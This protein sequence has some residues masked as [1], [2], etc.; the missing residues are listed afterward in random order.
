MPKRLPPRIA[1]RRKRLL[2]GAFFI[3]AAGGAGWFV[4]LTPFFLIKNIGVIVEGQ[5]SIPSTHIQEALTALESETPNILFF[6]PEK[7]EHR[8]MARFSELASA[9]VNRRLVRFPPFKKA[10]W[11]I[12]EVE[13]NISER[14][15]LGVT[16]GSTTLTTGRGRCYFFDRDGMLFRDFGGSTGFTTGG[17]PA[18]PFIADKRNVAY[19]LRYQVFSP[20]TAERLADLLKRSPAA[21][22]GIE[23]LE[24]TDYET[25][26][27]TDEGWVLVLTN[28]RPV[29]EQLEA[30]RLVL[31]KEIGPRRADLEYLDATIRNRVYYR[32]RS[33]PTQ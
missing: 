25:T 10:D 13:V 33:G 24:F 7:W 5:A 27:I 20:E 15:P 16:C 19:A 3:L 23:R 14:Q 6:S 31:E 17:T 30:A 28:A 4:F 32:F 2:W 12:N 11:F 9:D 21:D 22:V 26:L 8:L 29:D 1:R 18:A